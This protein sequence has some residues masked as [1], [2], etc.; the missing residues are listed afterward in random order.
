MSQCVDSCYSTFRRTFH[1]QEATDCS[2]EDSTSY[3]EQYSPQ[4][5]G[6]GLSSRN[7]ARQDPQRR[8]TAL[9]KRHET[10]REFISDAFD[11]L[12][13]SQDVVSEPESSNRE[14]RA[15]FRPRVRRIQQSSEEIPE[16]TKAMKRVTWKCHHNKMDHMTTTRAVN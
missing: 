4:S 13:P 12:P 7:R 10:I 11:V 1:N 15:S 9:D 2:E 6:D 5:S 16:I 8:V 14:R 3:A